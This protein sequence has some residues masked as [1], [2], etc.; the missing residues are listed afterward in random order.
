MSNCLYFSKTNKNA[1]IPYK[2][3]EDG[4]F[5]IYACFEEDY[6]AIPP[7]EI[8]F[9]STGIASSFPDNYVMVLKERGST[10]TKG[11]AVRSGVIDSGYRGEWIVPISNVT[12]KWIFITKMSKEKTIENLS[13]YIDKSIIKKSDNAIFYP[14]EKAICQA[15]L[16]TTPKI[17]MLEIEYEDLK[18]IKSERGEGKLGSSNK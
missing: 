12:E 15:L 10:G 18:N 13:C 1:K 3:E 7:H 8:R 5:D 11:M 14:Y 6:I 9:I 16:L 2:R 17:E 4:G